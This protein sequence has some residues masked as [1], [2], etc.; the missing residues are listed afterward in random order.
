MIESDQLQA[1]NQAEAV[2]DHLPSFN[3]TI[4]RELPGAYSVAPTFPS[5]QEV[6]SEMNNRYGFYGWFGHGSPTAVVTKSKYYNKQPRWCLDAEDN[7]EASTAQEV[8]NQ[9]ALDNLTNVNHPAI[10]YSIGCDHTPFDNYHTSPNDYNMGE[11]FT[12]NNLT[13]GPAFLGNTRFGWVYSS[14]HLFEEFADLIESGSCYLGVAELISKSNNNYSRHYLSYSHNL[15]GCPQTN[16]YRII[17]MS[18]NSLNQEIVK[19]SSDT[20]IPSEYKIIGNY[21][22]PFNPSTTVKYAL[23]YISNLQLT[24]YD[25]MGKEIK[26]FSLTNQSVGY[27]E[28]VWNG[29]NNNGKS[30]SSG[31]YFYKLNAVSLENDFEEFTGSAKL[32]LLK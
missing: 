1:N 19:N 3:T 29:T 4:W 18:K 20:E 28:I 31:I 27:S 17:P 5:G 23:P 14:Y 21:P 22:N 9:D 25:I 26:T 11:S 6:L 30:V 12:V 15:V 7:V 10:I 16:M 32:L 8:E 24:I 2:R 13:G